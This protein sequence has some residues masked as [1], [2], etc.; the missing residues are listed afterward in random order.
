MRGKGVE[1]V[2]EMIDGLHVVA[3]DGTT[4]NER[5]VSGPIRDIF[6]MSLIPSPRRYQT[7][8]GK[9]GSCR[10]VRARTDRLDPLNDH[11]DS[12]RRSV[13]PRTVQTRNVRSV[14]T[15]DGCCV[16]TG[17]RNKDERDGGEIG[18]CGRITMSSVAGWRERLDEPIL[19][20]AEDQ[21]DE[22]IPLSMYE[23]RRPHGTNADTAGKC[24]IQRA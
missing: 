20:E 22:F 13:P 8:A 5:G 3:T 16:Q 4:P 12:T 17:N 14:A 19:I 11:E 21:P 24:P 23:R 1:G 7:T 10:R 9:V 2:G 15:Q 18:G 6:W